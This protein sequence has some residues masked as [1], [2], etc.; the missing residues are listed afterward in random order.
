MKIGT[1]NIGSNDDASIARGVEANVAELRRRLPNM[2]ILLLG[3]L[4]RTD[5]AWTERTANINNIIR[6]LDNGNTIRFL[7]M[8]DHFYKGNGEFVWEFYTDLLHLT[9]AGYRKWAEV[10][11][12]LFRE[13]LGNKNDWPLNFLTA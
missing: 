8:R 7:D 6:Q 3:I 5:A 10:M 4:P 11:D 2:K 13:M 9:E 12:P 1:N